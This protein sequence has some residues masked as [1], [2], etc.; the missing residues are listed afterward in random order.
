V[1]DRER[2]AFLLIIALALLL[3]L[4]Y[5]FLVLPRQQADEPSHFKYVWL[6]AERRRL[7]APGDHEGPIRP[8]VYYLLSAGPLAI[9]STDSVE[10]QMYVVRVVSL[11]LYLL[12]LIAD[13]GV[14]RCLTL[15]GHWLRLMFPFS[16]A[17]LPGFANL[18]T[19]ANN[20]VLALAAR[21]FFLWPSSRLIRYGFTWQW[22]IGAGAL[23]LLCALAKSTC[24]SLIANKA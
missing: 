1:K 6:I 14:L 12:T 7:P 3:V 8:A 15:P 10:Q 22:L 24:P 18:M 17:A 5:I 11:G 20:D 23:A 2:W 4:I 19:S 9:L 16:I 21:A 13:Y